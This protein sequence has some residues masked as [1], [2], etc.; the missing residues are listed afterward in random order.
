ML[1]RVKLRRELATGSGPKRVPRV[2]CTCSSGASMVID[3]LRLSVTPV[4][5]RANF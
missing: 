2:S 3:V 4:G 1:I 5:R